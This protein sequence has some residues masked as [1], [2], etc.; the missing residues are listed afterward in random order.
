MPIYLM[1]VHGP[2]PLSMPPIYLMAKKSATMAS[3]VAT[4]PDSIPLESSS[5]PRCSMRCCRLRH[6]SVC[7]RR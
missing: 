7:S 3:T 1:G 6:A 5:M 2:Q 4:L